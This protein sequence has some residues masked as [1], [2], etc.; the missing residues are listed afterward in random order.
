LTLI[1]GALPAFPGINPKWFCSKVANSA[2]F[3][4]L[5]IAGGGNT[6]EAAHKAFLAEY[7]RHE[8]KCPRRSG[9]GKRRHFSGAWNL[10]PGWKWASW[11]SAYY[12]GPKLSATVTMIGDKFLLTVWK[13]T[14][15]LDEA[16]YRSPISAMNAAEV[17]GVKGRSGGKKR[18]GKG[19]R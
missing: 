6:P 13:G 8:R 9:G 19:K 2:V 16:E 18:H 3:D 11:D 7:N 14:T 15:K 5:R 17:M 12:A 1:R 4:A 10:N